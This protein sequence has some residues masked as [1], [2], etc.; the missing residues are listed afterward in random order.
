MLQ[1]RSGPSSNMLEL[2]Y[3]FQADHPLIALNFSRHDPKHHLCF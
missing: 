1:R 3:D 2:R